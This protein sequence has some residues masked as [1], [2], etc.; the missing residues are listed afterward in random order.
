M[1]ILILGADGYLG[2]PTCTYLASKG[3]QITAV[4]SFSKRRWERSLGVKPLVVPSTFT[5]RAS[6]WNRTHLDTQ[7]KT[8]TFDICRDTDLL[9]D[10]FDSFHP[11]AVVHYAEQPS[12]PY[13]MYS[14]GAAVETQRNNIVGTL[15][16]IHAVAHYNPTCHIVKLGTMGEYGTPNIQIEEGWLNVTHEGRS[17]RVLYPKKP[18]S[19]Y[20]ASKVHDS[21]NLEFGCRVW[22]L[23]VT[24][25]NQGIVY[26]L[27]NN[28]KGLSPA[29]GTSF[30]YDAVFGTVLNRFLVEAA[31]GRPLSVYGTGGQTRG[32]LDIRDTL[33][34][35]ELTLLNPPKRGEF[36]VFNQFTEQFSVLG[37]AQLV[38]E[39]TGAPIQ[40]VD[41]PRVEQEQH[42]YKAIHTSLPSL[43]LEPHLLS[44]ETIEML[45][46]TVRAHRDKVDFDTL[47]FMIP[48]RQK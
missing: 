20:H 48:W 27:T 46:A 36:R 35:V 3:H 42:Y 40:H 29:E 14:R 41:N 16:L 47:D 5:H 25:L 13:S 39:V 15:N 45:Y 9:Y 37:L 30:H 12:A 17:D 4:D 31:V 24:D 34:C 33:R 21:H 22:G 43:G 32:F 6:H 26:G 8:K 23:R 2:W 10:L 18:G 28:G 19:W 7:I 11:D 38:H 1:R 44:H